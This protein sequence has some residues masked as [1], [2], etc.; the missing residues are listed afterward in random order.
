MTRTPAPTLVTD[1]PETVDYEV[2]TEVGAVVYT[3]PLAELARR[4]VLQN[5]KRYGPL[6]I[7]EVTRTVTRKRIYR[8]RPVAPADTIMAVLGRGR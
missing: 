3:T 5:R 6:Q 1:A 4:W 8:T 7:D 2:V